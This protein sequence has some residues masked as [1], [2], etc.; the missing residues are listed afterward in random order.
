[1]TIGHESDPQSARALL[2]F[3]EDSASFE[4]IFSELKIGKINIG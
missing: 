4:S 2:L 3:Y 1:M